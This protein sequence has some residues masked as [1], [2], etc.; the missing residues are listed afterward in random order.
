MTELLLST[1]YFLGLTFS[2]CFV[3]GNIMSERFNEPA[4]NR[5]V[6]RAFT[7]P[8]NMAWVRINLFGVNSC[9]CSERF[10]SALLKAKNSNSDSIWNTLKHEL[11]LELLSVIGYRNLIQFF[12]TFTRP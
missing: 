10:F 12:F 6:V 11:N 7:S 8:T 3:Q 2:E 9:P 4:K 5:A 1:I